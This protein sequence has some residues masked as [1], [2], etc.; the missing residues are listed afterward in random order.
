MATNLKMSDDSVSVELGLVP[1]NGA[2]GQMLVKASNVDFDLEWQDQTSGDWADITNKPSEFPPAAHTHEMAEVNGLN[3]A[4][5]DRQLRVRPINTIATASAVLV[6][7]ALN[8]IVYTSNDGVYTF[9]VLADGEELWV[10]AAVAGQTLNS[11]ARY[12]AKLN[13]SITSTI[14][15]I[16]E[17]ELNCAYGF[18]AIRSNLIQ[19]VK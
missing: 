15:E 9:P 14:T 1:V 4:L 6:K 8:D 2:T 12:F 13:G 16:E 10:S 11:G 18:R 17:Y 7:N 19:G 3:A 5:D